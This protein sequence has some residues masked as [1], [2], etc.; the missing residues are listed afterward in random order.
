M[1]YSRT[2]SSSRSLA[3]LDRR[4]LQEPGNENLALD[5]LFL[6]RR[7]RVEKTDGMERHPETFLKLT[8]SLAGEADEGSWLIEALWR[9]SE[10]VG[11]L[12]NVPF[13]VA[14]SVKDVNYPI[15][16]FARRAVL[17]RGSDKPYMSGFLDMNGNLFGGSHQY[18]EDRY[19]HYRNRVP[20]NASEFTTAST[21]YELMK[22]L[23]DAYLVN[24]ML[25]A[26]TCA[27]PFNSTMYPQFYEGK[28][29]RLTDSE[30]AR[31]LRR[32]S[33]WRCEA[34]FFFPDRNNHPIFKN[35]TGEDRNRLLIWAR[36]V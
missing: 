29:S 4:F 9:F 1:R 12:P 35:L 33:R 15:V 3:A 28:W 7:L 26:N 22:M 32:A 19:Y 11:R 6:S 34:T 2:Q 30:K 36:Q 17:Y 20:P 5:L 31:A 25:T 16:S 18:L 14:F 10:E 27:L 8:E 13:R 24:G 23:K 21:L